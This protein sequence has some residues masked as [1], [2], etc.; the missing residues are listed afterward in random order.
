MQST[1]PPASGLC[2]L[3]LSDT[4][5]DFGVEHFEEPMQVD[6]LVQFVVVRA[7]LMKSLAW[8][9]GSVIAQVC[10]VSPAFNATRN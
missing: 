10:C 8:P 5:Q 7:D 9:T 1:S 6:R 3:A 4:A 2:Q